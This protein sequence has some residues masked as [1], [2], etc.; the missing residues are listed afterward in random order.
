MTRTTA[1]GI[2]T[3]LVCGGATLHAQAPIGTSGDAASPRVPR[4]NAAQVTTRRLLDGFMGSSAMIVAP[5]PDGRHFATIGETTGDL[6]IRDIASKDVRLLTLN[7]APYSPGFAL[8]AR[9]SRDGKRIA[10]SWFDNAKEHFEL[11]IT[12]T[13][14]GDSKIVYGGQEKGYLQP[15][16]WSP[17][18]RTVLASRTQEDGTVQIV[19]I[20]T[21]G[22]PARVLKTLDWRSP[23]R[24]NFSADGR[25]VVYDHPPQDRNNNRDIYIIDLVSNHETRVVENAAN[26]YVLGWGPDGKHIL[27]FSDRGGAPAAWLLPVAEGKAQGPATLAKSGLWRAMPV[28]FTPNGDYFYAVETGGRNVYL[29]TLDPTSGKVVG[30]PTPLTTGALGRSTHIAWS[31]DGR[32]MSYQVKADGGGRPVIGIRSLESNDQREFPMPVQVNY[33]G[34]Q[35]WSPDGSTL[36]VQGQERG[37]SALLR[38]DVHTG[39]TETLFKLND[40]SLQGF[41]LSPDGRAIVYRWEGV[42]DDGKREARLVER[43]IASGQ[44][45]VINRLS[46]G[47]GNRV[48]ELA[49][50]PQGDRVAFIR[51]GATPTTFELA[52]TPMSGGE[53]RTIMTVE[54]S[55]SIS[56]LAWARDGKSVLVARRG[57]ESM[58]QVVRVPEAGGVAETIGIALDNVGQLRVDP[59]GRRLAF[60]AGVGKSE[61][62]VMENI[63]AASSAARLKSR[64]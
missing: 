16:D 43:Q 32:M 8:F 24:M 28:A 56:S 55:A 36:L 42:A 62:W 33:I 38:V 60:D 27:F 7:T 57:V 29:A 20:P 35:R 54:G 11:G 4:P 52:I 5:L 17:D 9:V 48:R 50:S 3:I 30:A 41:D 23:L 63:K 15:E 45:R 61:L 26:D 46:P 49:V 47:G 13:S 21:D 19:L 12:S 58:R 37:N 53:A 25:Y 6:V 18:G 64:Q 44:E 40:A 39:K 1:I 51:L 14:G 31:P 34:D 10:Y 59:S 2:L 22:G